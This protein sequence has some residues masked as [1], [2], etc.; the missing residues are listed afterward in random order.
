MSGSKL[1]ELISI[2]GVAV[3]KPHSHLPLEPHLRLLLGNCNKLEVLLLLYNMQQAIKIYFLLYR[4]NCNCI[5][6]NN[7]TFL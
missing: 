5:P 3:L 2:F 7:N 1:S 6:E 4:L